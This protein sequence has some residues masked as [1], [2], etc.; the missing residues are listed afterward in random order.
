MHTVT[1]R[2]T[3]KA[4][5]S[6]CPQ[7]SRGAMTLTA[8]PA[9]SASGK[10]AVSCL[11]AAVTQEVSVLL[12]C[13]SGLG[14]E[15]LPRSA[16]WDAPV[17]HYLGPK[18]PPAEG[19]STCK[20]PWFNGASVPAQQTTNICCNHLASEVQRGCQ[21][22]AF[23]GPRFLFHKAKMSNPH[24]VSGSQAHSTLLCCRSCHD[25]LM[26]VTYQ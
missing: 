6:Q 24:H 14:S 17:L 2:L 3:C 23:V 1:G 16:H 9:H 18:L 7:C 10:E 20:P 26:T 22:F 4:Q 15:Q 8:P 25:A 5:A 12:A 19:C 11:Q 21:P 13:Q